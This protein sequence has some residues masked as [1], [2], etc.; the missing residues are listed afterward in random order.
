MGILMTDKVDAEKW[1]SIHDFINMTGMIL[2]SPGAIK[3]KKEKD[4]VKFYTGYKVTDCND[5]YIGFI[6]HLGGY[7]FGRWAFI[8]SGSLTVMVY[9]EHDDID[10]VKKDLAEMFSGPVKIS[11]SLGG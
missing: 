5:S 6:V 1:R 11:Q 8:D 7:L 4:G 10:V 2:I 9:G 3:S